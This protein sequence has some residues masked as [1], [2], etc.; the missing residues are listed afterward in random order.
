MGLSLVGQV[1]DLGS[2]ARHGE[3]QT[4]SDVAQGH[5]VLWLATALTVAACIG[6]LRI[7]HAKSRR[8]IST[9]WPPASR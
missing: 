2:H 7:G 3:F 5:S 9:C 6:A 4:A 8:G 1:V